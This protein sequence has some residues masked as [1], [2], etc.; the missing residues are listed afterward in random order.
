MILL[1]F[2]AYCDY[3][4]QASKETCDIEGCGIDIEEC[5]FV[6]V[7]DGDSIELQVFDNPPNTL[8]GNIDLENLFEATTF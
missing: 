1:H 7:E 3:E 5:V 4:D 8:L 2:G 6:P